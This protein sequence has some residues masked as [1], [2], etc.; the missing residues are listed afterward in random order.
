MSAPETFE[1]YNYE[2]MDF[3]RLGS[4][5]LTVHVKHIREKYARSLE[6]EGVL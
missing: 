4:F 5:A 2:V 3:L 6:S 1:P